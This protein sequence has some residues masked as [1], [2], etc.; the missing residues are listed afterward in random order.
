M[1]SLVCSR[2]AVSELG[3]DMP[4]IVIILAGTKE[5]GVMTATAEWLHNWQDL[6]SGLIGFLAAGLAIWFAHRSEARTEARELRALRIALAAEVAG[7]ANR[8]REGYLSALPQLKVHGSHGISLHDLQSVTKF[9]AAIVYPN[10]AAKIGSLGE[11]AHDVVV[12]YSKIEILKD[13]ATRMVRDL[14]SERSPDMQR[15]SP[16]LNM[17]PRP[18]EWDRM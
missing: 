12:F 5:G 18:P 7:Y 15:I 16:T 9:P 8:A 1:F 2:H 6:V 13:E 3:F 10:N 11:I 4:G 14:S 17:S